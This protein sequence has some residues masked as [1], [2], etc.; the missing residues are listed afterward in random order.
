MDPYFPFGG[1]AD[2]AGCNL[3][4]WEAAATVVQIVI[5]ISPDGLAH[6]HPVLRICPSSSLAYN[7]AHV[8][9]S[10]NAVGVWY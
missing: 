5:H 3:S 7:A 1:Y 10:E 6:M 8:P 9:P 2:H 4:S